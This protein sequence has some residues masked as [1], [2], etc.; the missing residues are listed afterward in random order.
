MTGVLQQIVDGISTGSIYA[1]LALALVLVHRATGVVNFA[2][3]T[4]GTIGAFIAWS[5]WNI[6]VPIWVAVLIGIV[7]A[8]PFGA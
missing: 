6:G 4:M 8:L 5:L 3:G 2:Q 1:A 7:F